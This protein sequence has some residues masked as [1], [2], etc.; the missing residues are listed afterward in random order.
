[1][2]VLAAVGDGGWDDIKIRLIDTIV[3]PVV[4]LLFVLALILFLWGAVVSIWNGG[5]ETARTKGKQHMLWGV[6]GMAIMFAAFAIMG[7]IFNTITSVGGN[8]G[9][10]GSPIPK[11]SIIDNGFN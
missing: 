8:K 10:D 9:V 7:F 4:A 3:E 1:M 2:Q 5:N 11:P 6:I